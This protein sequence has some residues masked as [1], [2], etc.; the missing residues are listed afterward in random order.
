MEPY[1]QTINEYPLPFEQE[2]I[3][4]LQEE[5]VESQYS[6]LDSDSEIIESVDKFHD[7][8]T[9]TLV[10]TDE[11]VIFECHWWG[12]ELYI[13]FW[14][15]QLEYGFKVDSSWE[16]MCSFVEM[17]DQFT[18]EYESSDFEPAHYPWEIP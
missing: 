4:T 6:L 17:M 15:H 3:I 7:K 14:N 8:Y 5:M 2:K 13:Y 11:W 10:R 18:D 9:H 12:H 16:V 1:L